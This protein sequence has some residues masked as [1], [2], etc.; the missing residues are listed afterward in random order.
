MLIIFKATILHLLFTKIAQVSSVAGG[1]DTTLSI[2]LKDLKKII[3]LK[4]YLFSKTMC[5]TASQFYACTYIGTCSLFTCTV[6]L[7]CFRTGGIF[8][9]VK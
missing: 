2:K 1:D 3:Y 9:K 6:S 8:I 5:T 4:M 7:S